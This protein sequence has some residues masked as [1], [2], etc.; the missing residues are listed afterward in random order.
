V[1]CIFL[2]GQFTEY[3]FVAA[4]LK[5]AAGVAASTIAIVRLIAADPC[6]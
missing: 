5:L 4:Q 2:A 6:V 3:P 1:T